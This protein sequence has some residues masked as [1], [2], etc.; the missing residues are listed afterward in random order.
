MM[1][2]PNSRA[3]AYDLPPRL[4]A[5]AAQRD[6]LTTTEAAALLNLKPQTLRKWACTEAGLL[7]PIRLGRRL[8]WSIAKITELFHQGY[9][10]V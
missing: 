2:K 10:Y 6:Y 8:A 9:T 4:A 3:T 7:R 1:E 5:L